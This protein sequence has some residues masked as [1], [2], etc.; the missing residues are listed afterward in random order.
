MIK[1]LLKKYKLH[2]TT[3]NRFR[4]THASLL[5]GEVESVKIVQYR[6]DMR[7]VKPQ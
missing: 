4:L 7:M 3:Q 2:R 5:L 6:L 1:I